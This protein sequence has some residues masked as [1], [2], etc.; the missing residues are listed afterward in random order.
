MNLFI[1]IGIL[2]LLLLLYILSSSR[3]RSTTPKYAERVRTRANQ[4]N[5]SKLPPVIVKKIQVG[6]LEENINE[7]NMQNKF[8]ELGLAPHIYDF[9]SC[10]TDTYIIMERLDIT[11]WFYIVRNIGE[12]TLDTLLLFY[13]SMVNKINEMAKIA[14]DAG[15]KHGDLTH[16][17]N[18]MFRLDPDGKTITEIKFIDFGRAKIKTDNRPEVFASSFDVPLNIVFVY[19]M[20]NN[21]YPIDCKPLLD[22]IEPLYTRYWNTYLQQDITWAQ[23]PINDLCRDQ[24]PYNTD[25]VLM[26]FRSILGQIKDYKQRIRAY[27]DILKAIYDAYGLLDT[28][29]TLRTLFKGALSRESFG[30]VN[31]CKSNFKRI[32]TDQSNYVTGCDWTLGK[33]LGSGSYGTVYESSCEPTINL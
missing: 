30:L 12:F 26:V 5:I 6:S 8:I 28:P 9:F 11:Y 24:D 3:K 14:N 2:V 19:F 15:L 17:N 27:F 33:E 18:V 1:L 25:Q 16:E 23:G 20:K 32:E 21:K 4:I 31:D 22:V 10:G 7:V 13:L 29:E